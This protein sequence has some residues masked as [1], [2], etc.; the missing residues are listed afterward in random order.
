[1]KRICVVCE[2][3]TEETFVRDVLVPAFLPL[4][5]MLVGQTVETSVGRKGGGLSYDRLKLHLRNQLRQNSAPIVTTLIDLYRLHPEFPAYADAMRQPSLESK[6]A[7]LNEAIHADVV[8]EAGCAP[9]RFIP[10]IQPYE[11]EALLFSDVDALVSVDSNWS[12]ASAA[13][14]KVRDA[15]TSPELIDDG[16]DT[17]PA[18][19]L[20]AH[21]HHPKFRKRLHGPQAAKRMGLSKIETECDHFRRWMECLRAIA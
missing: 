20:D 18:A 13:L 7:R 11:F 6:L 12:Q 16:P 5:L 10:H 1:M 15:V 2:G 14:K 8:A 21:L 3:Q 19:R 4:G 17:K 9:E